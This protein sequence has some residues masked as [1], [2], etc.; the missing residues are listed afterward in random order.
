M[1]PEDR[2]LLLAVG[3]AKEHLQR[4]ASLYRAF[5]GGSIP[6]SEDL[7]GIKTHRYLLAKR[8]LER[9]SPFRVSPGDVVAAHIARAISHSRVGILQWEPAVALD[10]WPQRYADLPP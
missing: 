1:R 7:H 10:D 3:N 9:L 8:D 4:A 6:L 2:R 5:A